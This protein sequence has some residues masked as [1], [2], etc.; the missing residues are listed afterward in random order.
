MIN[1]KPDTKGTPHSTYIKFKIHKMIHSVR[2]QGNSYLWGKVVTGK[3]P[4]DTGSVL[5]LDTG[6]GYTDVLTL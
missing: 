3:G 5:F 6:A 1:E 2:N 4:W